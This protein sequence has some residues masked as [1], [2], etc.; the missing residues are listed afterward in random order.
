MVAVALCEADGFSGS[1]SQEVELCSS[2][3]SASDG[4]NVEDIGGM[5]WEDALDAF[6]ADDSACGEGFVDSAAPACDDGAGEYLCADLVALF[7]AAMDV[8][9]IAYFEVRNVILQTF[10]FNSIQHFCLHWFISYVSYFVP[11][12]SY[13][14]LGLTI[15]NAELYRSAGRKARIF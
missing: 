11:C 4:Y 2:G 13:L 6:V 3:F 12:I 7:D 14:A 10:A 5:N 1:L 9:N 15:R 8:N